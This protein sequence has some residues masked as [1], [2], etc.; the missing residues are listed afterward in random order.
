MRT[1]H[2]FPGYLDFFFSSLSKPWPDELCKIN[3]TW[4]V[5]ARPFLL[6]ELLDEVVDANVFHVLLE[7]LVDLKHSTKSV[8]N[9]ASSLNVKRESTRNVKDKVWH[10]ANSPKQESNLHWEDFIQFIW[11]A[12]ICLI[13]I[14]TESPGNTVLYL[15]FTPAVATQQILCFLHIL[16]INQTLHTLREG[17]IYTVPRVSLQTGGHEWLPSGRRCRLHPDWTDTSTLLFYPPLG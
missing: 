14:R 2:F 8:I 7:L 11:N 5:F 6:R 9:Q 15:M 1:G 3:C 13:K 17:R 16:V 4:P 10:R 12:L